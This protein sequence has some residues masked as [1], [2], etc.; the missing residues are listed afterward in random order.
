MNDKKRRDAAITYASFLGFEP[1]GCTL[2]ELDDGFGL[3]TVGGVEYLVVRSCEVV[4]GEGPEKEPERGVFA[5]MA[6]A[7]GL[8]AKLGYTAREVAAATG[9]SYSAVCQCAADG[10]LESYLPR[11]M[12]RG[13]LMT[14]AMVDD[15]L[16]GGSDA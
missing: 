1:G 5:G 8:P 2:M 16:K 12:K 15:W 14:P 9:V 7:A 4:E 3:F 13:R 6:E 11:G 10:T